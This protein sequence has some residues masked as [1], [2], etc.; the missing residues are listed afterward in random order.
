[1]PKKGSNTGWYIAAVVIVI[2][3]IVVGVLA[4]KYAMPGTT[5]PSPSPSTS[6]SPSTSESPSPSGSSGATTMTIYAGEVSSS[7][8]GF[9]NSASSITSP[10][11]DITLKVGTTYTMTLN[12]AGQLPHGWEIVATKATGTPMF[13]AGIGVSNYI[14]PGATGTITFTP[15]QAGN[16]FYVCTVPGHV[17]LGMWGN[18]IVNP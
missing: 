18:V 12:N 4:Y 13:G 14:S 17:A 10:G 8:Y 3:I 16:F 5:N 15:N 7:Q 6:T 1:M 2:V 11:P 9:G